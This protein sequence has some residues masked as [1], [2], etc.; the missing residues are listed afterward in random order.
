MPSTVRNSRSRYG[1][2]RLLDS[3]QFDL[4][5]ECSVGRDI[6]FCPP[7]RSPSWEGLS[8]SNLTDLH[9]RNCLF[10]TFDQRVCANRYLKWCPRSRGV[11]YRHRSRVC[12]ILNRGLLTGFEFGTGSLLDGFVFDSTLQSSWSRPW[13]WRVQVSSRPACR[14]Q[15]PFWSLSPRAV[16]PTRLSWLSVWRYLGYVSPWRR[17]R[18][19]I[20]R[21]ITPAER[22]PD[23]CH[24][25]FLY[26][27]TSWKNL[28]PR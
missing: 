28:R 19:D 12:P 10:P 22:Q 25:R 18:H 4:E 21:I 16:S 13:P 11:E 9:S 3:D 7:C 1:S 2:D 23:K 14:R 15:W 17:H 6:G 24:Q 26:V 5:D 27:Q 20:S 8:T